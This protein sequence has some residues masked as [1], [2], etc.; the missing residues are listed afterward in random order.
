MVCAMTKNRQD[1]T[2]KS[3]LYIVYTSRLLPRL[4]ELIDVK[5]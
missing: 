5:S 2:K 1:R 4:S 3:G